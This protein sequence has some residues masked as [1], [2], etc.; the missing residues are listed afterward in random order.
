LAT[1]LRISTWSSAVSLPE[2]RFW[3]RRGSST[4]VPMYAAYARLIPVTALSTRVDKLGLAIAFPHCRTPWQAYAPG[5]ASSLLK[6]P[7]T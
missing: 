1:R 3:A 6:G 7:S 2:V 5:S 4:R